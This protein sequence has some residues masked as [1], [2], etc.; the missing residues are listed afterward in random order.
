MNWYC[1]YLKPKQTDVVIFYLNQYSKLEYLN[2]LYRYRKIKNNKIIEVTEE[3]FPRYLFVQATDEMV[4]K[5]RY[6]RGVQK[7]IGD[8]FGNPHIVPET[9]IDTIKSKMIDGLIEV[10]K[11]IFSKGDKVRILSGLFSN[12]EGIFLE[13][14]N[15]L[16]RTT[17]LLNTIYSSYVVE[18]DTVLLAKAWLL[19]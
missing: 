10:E 14:K 17:I 16:E 4:P 1:L 3:L 8:R 19:I 15:S 5:L 18:V 13:Y 7:V 11:N 12:F 9:V 2:P 6:Y